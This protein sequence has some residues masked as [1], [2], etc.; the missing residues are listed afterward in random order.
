MADT[1][2]FFADVGIHEKDKFRVFQRCRDGFSMLS[3]DEFVEIFG[4]SKEVVWKEC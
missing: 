1:Y 4:I 2:A 3:N